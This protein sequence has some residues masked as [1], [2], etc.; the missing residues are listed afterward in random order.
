MN[1]PTMKFYIRCAWG[2]G[3]TEKREQGA[4][5]RPDFQPNNSHAGASS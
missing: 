3:Q 5:P 1:Q 4:H 2:A